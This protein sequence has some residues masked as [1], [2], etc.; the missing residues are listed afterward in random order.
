MFHVAQRAV[1]SLFPLFP[2]DQA[3]GPCTYNLAIY[4]AANCHVETLEAFASAGANV[5]AQ[6][7]SGEKRGCVI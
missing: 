1:R 3:L 5:H 7:T 4:F 6:I 2:S